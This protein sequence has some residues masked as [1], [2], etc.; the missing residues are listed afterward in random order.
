M[1]AKKATTEGNVSSK[2]SNT[3]GEKTANE[4]DRRQRVRMHRGSEHGCTTTVGCTIEQVSLAEAFEDK[5]RVLRC[6]HCCNK[7]RIMK[8]G[9][10]DSPQKRELKC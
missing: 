5:Q 7:E 10:L 3:R 4:A 6:P 8:N 2:A 9:D 1:I